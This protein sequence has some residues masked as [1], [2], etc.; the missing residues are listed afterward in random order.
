MYAC[1]PMWAARVHALWKVAEISETDTGTLAWIRYRHR[2]Q[3]L[4]IIRCS[5]VSGTHLLVVIV[6]AA[7]L[8]LDSVKD[9]PGFGS[10][11]YP[12]ALALPSDRNRS[13]IFA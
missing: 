9:G 7:V 13:I 3:L 10:F 8:E 2:R 12:L 1:I 4:E 6:P 5:R 11:A